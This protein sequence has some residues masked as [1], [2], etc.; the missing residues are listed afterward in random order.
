M[1]YV[2][3]YPV[4]SSVIQ[5]YRDGLWGKHEYSRWPQDLVKNMWHIA[6]IP[7]HPESPDLPLVL[8]ESLL[9]ETHWKEDRTIGFNGIGYIVKETQDALTTASNAAIRRFESMYA[10][11]KVHTYGLH[12]V[13]ILRQ[14]VDRMRYYPVVP[15]IAIAVAAHIQRVCLEL[16]GLKTYAE[17]VAKRLESDDDY[18]RDILPVVGAFVRTGFDGQECVRVGLPTW[19]VRPLTHELAVWK[20]VE[21]SHPSHI[22]SETPS[23][24]PM[25]QDLRA[26]AEVS[27][28]G[29]DW[30]SCMLLLVSEHV[31]GTHLARMSLAQVPNLSDDECEPGTKRPRLEAQ[32][33]LTLPTPRPT[34]SEGS[35]KSRRRRKGA[36]GPD[37][38]RQLDESAH[39]PGPANS[40]QS[41]HS[42]SSRPPSDPTPH[43]SKSFTPS[44]FY[45]DYPVWA[46]ALRA[47]SPLPR[48]ANSAVY[49]YPPPFL[50]DTVCD[51]ASLPP[52][53]SH[54]EYARVDEKVTRYLHNFV[55]IREFCRL[56]LF[57]VT[58][59]HEPLTIAEWRSA[60][61]GDYSIK[62]R[63]LRKEGTTSDARRSVRRQEERRGVSRLFGRVG[64]LPSYRGDETI[65]VYGCAVDRRTVSE[66]R[67][68]VLWECHHVNFRA[69]L[70]AL[71][72]QLVQKSS[73][74]FRLRL[75]RE[76]FVSKV[77]GPPSSIMSVFP[78]ANDNDRRCR[79]LAP[80]DERCMSC[81]DYLRD[82]CAV[83][84][85]WP[86][87]PD[88]VA[89][90]LSEDAHEGQF[91][92]VQRLAVNFYVQTFVKTY[93]RLPI[94]PIPFRL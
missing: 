83:L 84:S 54:P 10:P 41:F 15:G 69:E 73:W 56:R 92:H 37:R 63:P 13:R 49:F 43:P 12:L 90:G 2:P 65:E 22:P 48:T 74:S 38:S 36:Q 59:A 17:V 86:D 40:S 3:E 60:L 61:W 23:N 89:Q 64:H 62:P 18:S 42:V 8:W 20:V 85:Y 27:N 71:D 79:W 46:T 53:C 39:N 1:D 30:L 82:F 66:V 58:I 29:G 77:W 16:A 44:P 51:E 81:M 26:V 33:H 11:G 50:L 19:V 24:P 78:T 7:S 31:A 67:T 80:P 57:D 21:C 70:L 25:S 55:R 14:V 75:E 72:T 68:R 94:P 47:C 28:A 4:S 5:T 52:T 32:V 91:G 9:P 6:C 45:E 76:F 87:C 35:K 93:A 34:N 88:E